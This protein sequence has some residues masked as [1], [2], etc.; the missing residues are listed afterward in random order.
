MLTLLRPA[1]RSGPAPTGW[2]RPLHLLLPALL[3][4]LLVA[5]GPGT[6]TPAHAK[7][8]YCAKR[9]AYSTSWGYS[10]YLFASGWGA[11]GWRVN[12]TV[13]AWDSCDH[14][15]LD[16]RVNVYNANVAAKG[17]IVTTHVYY[18]TQGRSGWQAAAPLVNR[19]P[20]ASGWY[21]FTY[22]TGLG[23]GHLDLCRTC[24]LTYVAFVTTV[25]TKQDGSRWVP[26]ARKQLTLNLVNPGWTST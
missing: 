25:W 2:R 7:D 6:A 24:R 18:A 13:T 11:T 5:L 17:G 4:A 12:P 26:L 3:T 16:L 10:S 23:I 15:A 22:T 20:A 8:Y 19:T 14:G 1:S 9:G 21:T